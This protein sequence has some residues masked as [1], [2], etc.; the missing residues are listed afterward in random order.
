MA[1]RP[2]VVLS[3]VSGTFSAHQFDATLSTSIT[4]ADGSFSV[5]L[6]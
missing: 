2:M 6:D 1:E 4:T 5:V 3:R